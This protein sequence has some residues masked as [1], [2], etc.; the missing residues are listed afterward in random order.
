MRSWRDMGLRG[1]PETPSRGKLEDAAREDGAHGTP[2]NA[3]A[4]WEGAEAGPT[5]VV[6]SLGYLGV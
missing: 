1:T 6:S 5:A 3:A 4:G 2:L